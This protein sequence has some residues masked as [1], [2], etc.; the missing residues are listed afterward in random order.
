MS[1]KYLNPAEKIEEHMRIRNWQEWGFVIYRGTYSDQT[2]WT[3]CL[4]RIRYRLEETLS[5]FERLDLLDKFVLTV[6]EDASR[7]D[8]ARTATIREDFRNWSAGDSRM[9]LQQQQQEQ[10]RRQ[11]RQPLSG[12][13]HTTDHASSNWP[14]FNAR[15]DFCI[16]IDSD[17]LTSIV[18][19]PPPSAEDYM[20]SKDDEG[21][22]KM[23]KLLWKPVADDDEDDDDRGP[24]IE[25]CTAEDVGWMKVEYGDSMV[26]FYD[27][28]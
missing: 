1:H 6:F 14:T 20:Y 19:G 23:I 13:D 4:S 17:S 27:F 25:G 26:E 9:H 16:Y 10:Q 21:W 8:G 12:D 18:N 5:S 15:H 2:A 11:Q 24:P 22:V 28:F 7:F 3:E